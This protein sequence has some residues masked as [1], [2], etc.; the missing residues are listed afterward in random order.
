MHSSCMQAHMCKP[1]VHAGPAPWGSPPAH[2]LVALRVMSQQ[3]P[4]GKVVGLLLPSHHQMISLTW[5]HRSDLSWKRGVLNTNINHFKSNGSRIEKERGT[6]K[7]GGK[8]AF[9]FTKVQLSP[10]PLRLWLEDK[11]MVI[12]LW[13]IQII[14]FAHLG[15][16]YLAAHSL[17]SGLPE[18]P[19]ICILMYVGFYTEL[20]VWYAKSSTRFRSA[21]LIVESLLLRH[22]SC[23]PPRRTTVFY[24]QW[25]S[26]GRQS[27]SQEHRRGSREPCSTGLPSLLLCPSCHYTS[28]P[29]RKIP[30]NILYRAT[31]VMPE[32]GF[33]S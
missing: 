26:L 20:L 1:C 22:P 7:H 23:L 9:N 4:A 15:Q 29:L 16:Y 11:W 24:S 30:G 25:R 5:S 14:V 2:P 31:P 10:D 19:S 33:R 12:F 13:G 3:L 17:V 6:D 32:L 28:K 18:K 21:F 8:S 27:D